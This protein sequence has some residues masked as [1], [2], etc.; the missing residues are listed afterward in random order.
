MKNLLASLITHRSIRTTEAK[1]KALRPLAEKLIT[2][3]KKDTLA[4]RRQARSILTQDTQVKIL[5]K[6]IAPKLKDRPGGYTRIIKT[7]SRLGD[8]ANTAIIELILL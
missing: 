8:G 1:A 5:F 2:L 3:A 7:G 6:T 4:N